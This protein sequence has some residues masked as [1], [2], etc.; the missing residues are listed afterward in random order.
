MGDGL[1]GTASYFPWVGVFCR[2][3]SV[4]SGFAAG[5]ICDESGL[6]GRGC[7]PGQPP[8]VPAPV[9]ENPANATNANAS[10]MLL[11]MRG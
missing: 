4:V 2:V 11:V 9:Q 3:V 7:Q 1:S 10:V 6:T 5:A 8:P